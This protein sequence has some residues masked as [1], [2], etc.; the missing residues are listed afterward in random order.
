MA[1]DLEKHKMFVPELNIEV[2]PYTIAVQALEQVQEEVMV[3]IDQAL[4]DIQKSINTLGEN[5]D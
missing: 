2:V 4:N 1:I 5:I 3:K